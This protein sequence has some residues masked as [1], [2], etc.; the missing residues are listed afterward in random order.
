MKWYANPNER[1][2]QPL[3]PREQEIFNRQVYGF[4]LDEIA[5]ALGI[6]KK[7]AKNHSWHIRQKLGCGVRTYIGQNFV[8]TRT[9]CPTRQRYGDGKGAA[10][11]RDFRG[12][13]PRHRYVTS[14]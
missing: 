3:T 2:G 12:F 7:T 14:A 8:C 5:H 13:A 10:V 6:S 11:T 1:V 4:Q 9:A